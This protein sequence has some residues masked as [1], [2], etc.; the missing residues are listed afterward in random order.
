MGVAVGHRKVGECL[1]DLCQFSK[2]LK[3][4]EQYLNI[5]ESLDSKEEIQRAYA[6]IGRIWYMRYKAEADNDEVGGARYLEKATQAFNY[7]LKA[8]EDLEGVVQVKELMEM[9][10]RLYL[11]L[12]LVAEEK[13][14]F[15]AA[16]DN[17]QQACG[18]GK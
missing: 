8:C 5:V 12:G 4:Q 9:R 14:D 16:E 7:G 17:Y 2:A 1:A 18:L 13:N 15:A 6:T 10:A 11:N 3:E